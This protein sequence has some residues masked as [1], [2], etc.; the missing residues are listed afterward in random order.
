LCIIYCFGS[1]KMESPLK[2]FTCTSK[3]GTRFANKPRKSLQSAKE[4]GCYANIM[5]VVI[6][7]VK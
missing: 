2:Y 1:E 3:N 6:Y 5:C 7:L 4:F